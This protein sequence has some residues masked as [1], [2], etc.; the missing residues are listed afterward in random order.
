MNLLQG[1]CNWMEDV[2]RSRDHLPPKG[3]ET[4]DY[5]RSLF[6]DNLLARGRYCVDGRPVSLRDIEVPIFAVGTWTDHVAPWR[7][8][9][10]LNLLCDT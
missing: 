7:S 4:A 2:Q 8:V 9:Y 1:A 6:H 3:A 5:L 10:K